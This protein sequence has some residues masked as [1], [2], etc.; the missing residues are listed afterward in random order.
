MISANPEAILTGYD[1][2]PGRRSL[3]CGGQTGVRDLLVLLLGAVCVI[4]GV[5]PSMLTRRKT[6]VM[7]TLS[8]GVR[9]GG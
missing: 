3:A 5:A 8:R 4:D 7:A 1:Q 6:A 9:L 2:T